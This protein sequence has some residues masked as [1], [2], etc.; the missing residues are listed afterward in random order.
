[1][2]LPPN[3]AAWP[4]RW[5][6]LWAERAAIIEY[7]ANV[8]RFTAETRAEMDIRKV[9]ATERQKEKVSA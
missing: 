3:P 6:E 2:T 8:S 9:A 7:E 4:P 1:M 5:K